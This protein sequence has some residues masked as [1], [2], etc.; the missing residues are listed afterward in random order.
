MTTKQTF[1]SFS[2]L[3]NTSLTP[4]VVCFY[5]NWCGYCKQY[6][7]ILEQVKSQLGNRIKVVRIDSDKYPQLAARYE[8]QALPTTL[9]FVKGE[10]VSRI[11]GGVDAANLL[12][13]IQRFLVS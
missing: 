6:V 13:H 9:I 4:V 11:Q 1:S 5:A 2:D 7:P 3:I 10:P 8:V 12:G